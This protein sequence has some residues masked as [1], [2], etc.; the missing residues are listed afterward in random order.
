MRIIARIC[1]AYSV[2]MTTQ[3]KMDLAQRVACPPIAFELFV[4]P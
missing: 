2:A 1:E 4:Q 3:T